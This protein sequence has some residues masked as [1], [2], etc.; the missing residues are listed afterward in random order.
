MA[1][2]DS[3]RASALRRFGALVIVGGLAADEIGLMRSA[4][5]HGLSV[6][7]AWFVLWVVVTGLGMTV[8]HELGHLLVAWIL[9]MRV[10]GVRFLSRRSRVGVPHV[11][12]DPDPGSRWLPMR[13][14]AT[15]LAGPLANLACAAF[16]LHLSERP[17]VTGTG[18]ALL[19]VPVIWGGATGLLNLVPVAQRYGGLLSDGAQIL[20]WATR[21]TEM[22][23]ALAAK[24]VLAQLAQDRATLSR[25]ELPD[26]ARLRRIVDGGDR[27]S[28]GP[29]ALILMTASARS[30]QLAYDAAR[31]A[32]VAGA[33]GLDP[34]AAGAL[35]SGIAWYR[36]NAALAARVR[37]RVVPDPARLEELAALAELAYAKTPEPPLTRCALAL[38]H[39]LRDRPKAARDLLVDPDIG[40]AG[41]ADRV[42]T[43]AVRAL[44]ELQLGDLAQAGSLLRSASAENRPSDLLTLVGQLA[45]SAAARRRAQAEPS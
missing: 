40:L 8:V 6:A 22:R 31:L 35:A 4:G 32:R 12:M 29:A 19:L 10:T 43:Y 42:N 18:R 20:R 28:V 33:S 21:P 24:S 9:R 15:M 17:G 7:L 1:Q 37:D 44:A 45:D 13:F 38:V 26:L 34:S 3:G 2:V 25:G 14:I 27:A 30:G 11:A 39:C 36:A 41:P 5:R 16:C 23:A